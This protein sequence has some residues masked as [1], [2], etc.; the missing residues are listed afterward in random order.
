MFVLVKFVDKQKSALWGVGVFGS[1]GLFILVIHLL[2]R[3]NRFLE[4]SVVKMP[5]PDAIIVGAQDKLIGDRVGADFEAKYGKNGTKVKGGNNSSL[6]TSAAVLPDVAAS[7]VVAA[8]IIN[9]S[10]VAVGIGNKRGIQDIASSTEFSI[11]NANNQVME[12]LQ[13]SQKFR[14]SAQPNGIQIGEKIYADSVILQPKDNGLLFLD[15]HWYRGT[16][17]VTRAADLLLVVNNALP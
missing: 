10:A 2:S 6:V 8:P 1:L 14:F 5:V 4:Q 9:R 17:T 15:G 13:A 12:K 7:R 16:F 11:L 3:T